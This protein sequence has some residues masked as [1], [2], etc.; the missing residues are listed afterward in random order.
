MYVLHVTINVNCIKF[1]F[2]VFY[3]HVHSI[4]TCIYMVM[5]MY[6]SIMV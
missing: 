4:F 2:N 1:H 5:Y 6:T 3:M